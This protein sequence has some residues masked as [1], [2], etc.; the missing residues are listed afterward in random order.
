M[1]I[2]FRQDA[3]NSL[4]METDTAA[5]IINGGLTAVA[6][7]V[8][9]IL[10]NNWQGNKAKQVKEY[11]YYNHLAIIS[12]LA[13]AVEDFYGQVNLY[14]RDYF[15]LDGDTHA[16]ISVSAV[17]DLSDGIAKIA[18]RMDAIDEGAAHIVRSVSHLGTVHY[19]GFDYLHRT[20]HALAERLEGICNSVNSIEQT[21]QNKFGLTRTMLAALWQRLM[22]LKQTNPNDFSTEMLAQTESYRTIAE[23]YQK[24][25]AVVE[26]NRAAVNEAAQTFQDE[27]YQVLLEE[28]E[29]RKKNAGF[30]EAIV[31]IGTVVVSAVVIAGSGGAGI[32]LVVT[33]G[34]VS[35]ALN[36]G[37]SS[38]MDQQIGT[39]GYPG[40]VDWGTVAFATTAGGVTGALTSAASFGF[41]QWTQGFA[42][43]G[44]SLFAKKAGADTLKSVAT[45]SLNR[46]GDAFFDSVSSGKSFQE[47]LGDSFSAAIDGNRI[48][49]DTAGGLMGSIFSQGAGKGLEKLENK[50]FT[51]HST[52]TPYENSIQVAKEKA[53][54]LHQ[55]YNI[56]S[57]TL[58]E[59]GKGIVKR[60][61]STYARTLD[62]SAAWES[63]MDMDEIMMDAV[64]TTASETATTVTSDIK[65][66]LY[67]RLNQQNE[68]LDEIQETVDEEAREYNKSFESKWEERGVKLT[69]NGVPDWSGTPDCVAEA[70]VEQ[71]AVDPDKV[72]NTKRTASVKDY[73]NAYDEMNREYNL[74]EKGYEWDDGNVIKHE[75]DGSITK[76]T[77]HH[78][79][80][81]VHTGKG[82]FQLVRTEVHSV[83]YEG[84]QHSGGAS[85]ADKAYNE[86]GAGDVIKSYNEAVDDAKKQYK[87]VNKQVK[88]AK[89]GGESGGKI[90]VNL[91]DPTEYAPPQSYLGPEFPFLP[92]L[93]EEQEAMSDVVP[94]NDTASQ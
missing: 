70:E 4:V 39:V 19:K 57:E 37:F 24:L 25:A 81:N 1:G 61:S 26:S 87:K 82:R 40:T 9:N 49:G 80:Y 76:Y 2:V 48:L 10:N 46:A 65:T 34:T 28:Y 23:T 30:W 44:L 86:Y 58:K 92:P 79:Q 90:T 18:S 17:R 45:G 16:V 35:S 93:E 71:V 78:V 85:Q 22:E 11:L 59:T 54:I 36:A 63:A 12:S 5:G 52:I 27:T 6:E 41:S 77:V 62:A 91:Q 72:K 8:Q 74:E 32:G 83:E 67:N 84:V 20:T 94:T 73:K 56:G 43:E 29:E 75:P 68:M 66:D 47:S 55:A 42:G 38:Y 51:N 15:N 13:L 64:S 21:Y 60:G 89:K 33:L 14:Y 88:D 50:L 69:E 3:V 31:N 53:P 7:A